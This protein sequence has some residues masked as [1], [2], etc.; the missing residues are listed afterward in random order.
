M[1]TWSQEYYSVD[2][3]DLAN[4]AYGVEVLD[5][6]EGIPSR[7]GGNIAVPN[8]PGAIWRPKM[9]AERTITLAMWVRERD[10]DDQAGADPHARFN[11][12][13]EGL[14]RLFGVYHRQV[15]LTKRKTLETGLLTLTSLGE[16]VN[17]LDFTEV[18]RDIARFTV[19]LLL[20]DPFWYG[21]EVAPSLSSGAG[22]ITNAGS[23]VA[24]KMKIRFNGSVTN[25]T[26]TNT[27][28][29]VSVTYT[30]T[31]PGGQWVELDTGLFT[32]VT[33][34]GVNVTGSVSHGGAAS[35]MEL[36]PGVNSMSLSG[37]SATVTYSTPYL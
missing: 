1:A 9:P 24:Y 16:C 26:V 32:A 5:G 14:K 13:M 23:G 25:P 29:N 6:T 21:S 17:T 7:R 20:N 4:Y 36:Y 11:A 34:G 31:I 18:D 35:W 3:Q 27:S 2:G 33:N 10:V 8:R 15:A 12:N 30:G 37:G 22:S 28:G 19:D